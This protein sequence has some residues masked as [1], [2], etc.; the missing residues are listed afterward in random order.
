[1]TVPAAF[2]N[3]LAS[4]YDSDLIIDFSLLD[5]EASRNSFSQR[6][7]KPE[8]NESELS[9]GS[10]ESVDSIEYI[11]NAKEPKVIKQVKFEDYVDSEVKDA[12]DMFDTDT[13]M[14]DSLSENETVVFS[15]LSD[16]E[17]VDEPDPKVIKLAAARSVIDDINDILDA[18][19]TL[20][21]S[22]GEMVLR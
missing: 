21:T 18:V 13:S 20:H 9:T 5:A 7:S 10:T 8:E 22:P 15:F 2:I 16:S 14:Y 4:D 17:I 3:N 6:R 12:L 19:H 11:R 1:M